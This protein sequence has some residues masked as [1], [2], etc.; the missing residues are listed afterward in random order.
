MLHS[1]SVIPTTHLRF[2]FWQGCAAKYSRVTISAKK[3]IKSQLLQSKCDR[4]HKSERN[5]LKTRNLLLM[6]YIHFNGNQVPILNYS[7]M[8][9]INK[10]CRLNKSPLWKQNLAALNTTKAVFAQ[11]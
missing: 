2:V 3:A 5:V 1:I 7:N 8:H 9:K 10:Y 11:I 6:R 4:A